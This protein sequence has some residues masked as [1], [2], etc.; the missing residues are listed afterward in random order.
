[1]AQPWYNRGDYVACGVDRA[2][3]A[4]VERTRVNKV[5][6]GL[7]NL[8]REGFFENPNGDLDKYELS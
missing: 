4:L 5:A 8:V 1:M 2:V 6:H 3:E 7:S